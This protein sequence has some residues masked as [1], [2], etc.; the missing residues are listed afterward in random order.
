MQYIQWIDT[1]VDDKILAAI[2]TYDQIR[3]V[4]VDLCAGIESSRRWL[5]LIFHLFECVVRS[6]IEDS[7]S[8]DAERASMWPWGHLAVGY[9]L[10]TI[11]LHV[12]FNRSPTGTATLAV[13]VGTQ[14]PDLIDKPLAWTFDILAAGRSFAHSLLVTTV[15]I[16]LVF[17]I[18]ARRD[19]TT[20]ALAFGTGY[21]SHLAADAIFPL[22]R[23]EYGDLAY[24]GWP[25]TQLSPNGGELGFVGQVMTIQVTPF[26][27]LQLVFVAIAFIVWWYD[28]APALDGISI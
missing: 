17:I 10:Y 26:F 21:L 18:A 7:T 2:A 24:L 11:L 16:V 4:N 22:I 20:I 8:L 5:Y 27:T 1:S 14:F 3:I 25:I 15:V 28:D 12:Y 6:S 23:S 13:A 9:L 19:R